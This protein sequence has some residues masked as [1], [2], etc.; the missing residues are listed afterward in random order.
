MLLHGAHRMADDDGR[1]LGIPV[2]RLR[3]K[4]VADDILLILALEGDLSHGHFVAGV[5]IV[6][7]VG[8]VLSFGAEGI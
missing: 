6:R 7:A 5:K 8:E 1:G 2:E 3:R 4:E